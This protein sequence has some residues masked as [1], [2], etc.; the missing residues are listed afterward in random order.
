[1]LM[2]LYHRPLSSE[3]KMC[4]MTYESKCLS[5]ISETCHMEEI[6]DSIPHIS[7]DKV[8][9]RTKMSCFSAISV[10]KNE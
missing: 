10:C 7:V 8:K 9:K 5:E 3:K 6:D 2:T 1:M 4:F